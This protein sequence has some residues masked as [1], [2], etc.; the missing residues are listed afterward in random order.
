MAED[1]TGGELVLQTAID[2]AQEVLGNR[3][4]AVFAL[5]S[6]AHGGFAP[7]V[8]DVDVALVLRTVSAETGTEIAQIGRLVRL[9]CADPLADR[10]S[11]FWAD[12][13]GVRTGRFDYGRLPPVDRLDLIE[14]GRLLYG[15][16]P[17]ASAQPPDADELVLNGAEFAVSRFDD[18]YLAE[19][20]NPARLLAKGVRATTK[21]VLFPP[22]FLYTLN[23]HRIGHNDD[24]VS[25]YLKA[26]KEP[27][28]AEAALTW[29]RHGIQD[30]PRAT[31]LAAEH[32][33]AMYR[34][35]L[36]AY[37]PA[38]AAAGKPGL[39]AGLRELRHRLDGA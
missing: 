25:W 38:V 6:L 3:L 29:R 20:K 36:D 32:L 28:L 34:E 4:V 18:A 21:T 8:S 11:I 5:G 27:A 15:A 13:A 19:V 31:A 1:S 30:V 2:A 14:S 39:G 37:I 7:L 23:T 26:G 12:E 35:F 33:T 10:L 17:R 22:R 24:A 9:N 16:D